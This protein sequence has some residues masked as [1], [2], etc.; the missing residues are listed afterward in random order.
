MSP[1]KVS[2]VGHDVVV[3]DRR[4]ISALVKVADLDIPNFDAQRGRLSGNLL[5]VGG[6]GGGLAIVDLTNPADSPVAR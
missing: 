6:S 1:M 2:G 3:I 5:Y 4:N